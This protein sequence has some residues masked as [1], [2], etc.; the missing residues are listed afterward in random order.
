MDDKPEIKVQ[1]EV[2][3]KRPSETAIKEEAAIAENRYL[4]EDANRQDHTREQSVRNAVNIAL[5]CA[6]VVGTLIACVFAATWAWHMLT[7]W[8][9]LTPEQQATLNSLFTGGLISTL[10]T[11]A[12]QKMRGTKP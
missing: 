4:Q 2:P 12:M 11:I 6:I 10:L 5:R 7:P 9:Y 1:A 3:R 8:P